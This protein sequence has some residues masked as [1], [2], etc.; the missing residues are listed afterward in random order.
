MQQLTNPALDVALLEHERD[1]QRTA[2]ARARASLTAAEPTRRRGRLVAIGLIAATA[3]LVAAHPA[4]TGAADEYPP[5]GC[6]RSDHSYDFGCRVAVGRP[7]G[8]FQPPVVR[9]RA[10]VVIPTNVR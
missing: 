10:A 4:S 9:E 5:S 1:R 2:A 8:W 6:V 3:G 7:D